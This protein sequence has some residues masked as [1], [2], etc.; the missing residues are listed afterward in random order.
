MN[1]CPQGIIPS[2]LSSSQLL[3]HLETKRNKI[4]PPLQYHIQ[5]KKGHHLNQGELTHMLVPSPL[6]D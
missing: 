4:L 3:E 5:M 2:H 6:S 1:V